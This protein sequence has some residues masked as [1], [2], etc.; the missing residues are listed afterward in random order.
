M[1]CRE[2]NRTLRLAR[3]QGRRAKRHAQ[4]YEYARRTASATLQVPG[5]AGQGP[6]LRANLR[7]LYARRVLTRSVR[8]AIMTRLVNWRVT[9][10]QWGQ[11]S[12]DSAIPEPRS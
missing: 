6:P 2:T 8:A 3:A 11:K 9:T 5:R 10:H 7:P 12:L 4:P 1:R